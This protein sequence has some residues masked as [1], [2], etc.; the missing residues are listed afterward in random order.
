VPENVHYLTGRGFPGKKEDGNMRII[1]V[2]SLGRPGF[3]PDPRH[4]HDRDRDRGWWGFDDQRRRR[5]WRWDSRD[6]RW[7]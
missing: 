5:F 4:E 3:D 2:F 1:E 6:N 7:Y